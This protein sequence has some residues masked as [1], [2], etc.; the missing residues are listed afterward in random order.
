MQ[1]T[2]VERRLNRTLEQFAHHDEF[3]LVNDVNELSVTH[4][5]GEYIHQEFPKWDVD[6]EY[7]RENKTNPKELDDYPK[8]R[9]LPDIIVHRR[10]PESQN[11]ENF[12]VI[13]VKANKNNSDEPTDE[14]KIKAYLRELNYDY[15]V[16]IDFR[17]DKSGSMNIFSLNS[18]SV[19]E[20]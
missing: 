7:N 5:L 1:K 15:G 2:K 14:K 18:D 3:L 20:A 4:K 17:A 6:C 8:E 11:G 12:I 9:V 10:G 16:T 13:E 19:V